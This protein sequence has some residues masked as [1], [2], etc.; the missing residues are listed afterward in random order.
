M[1]YRVVADHIRTLC[2]SIADGARPGSDGRDYVL[3]RIL[4]RAVRYG[5]ETLGASEGFFAQL[6]DVVVKAFGDFYPELV[7][8]RDTIHSV[9]AEEEA[10]F[11]KTLVKGIE[12]FK[13]AAAGASGAVLSGQEVGIGG[14]SCSCPEGVLQQVA[15]R[16]IL[17]EQVLAGMILINWPSPS[18]AGIWQASVVA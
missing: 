2:F 8:S 17:A 11:S 13:K 1:A 15:C 4:R 12:R 3:R 18:S 7:K 9:I 5:R 6:V 10:S 14:R 16:N